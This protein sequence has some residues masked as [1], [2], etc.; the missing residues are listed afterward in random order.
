MHTLDPLERVPELGEP[1]FGGLAIDGIGSFHGV[2]ETRGGGL[3]G[4]GL[5]EVEEEGAVEV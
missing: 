3:E 1:V 5:G 4:C 2:G